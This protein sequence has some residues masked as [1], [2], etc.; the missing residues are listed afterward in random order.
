MVFAKLLHD[1]WKLVN[2]GRLSML[3][4][5]MESQI[6]LEEFFDYCWPV[7]YQMS[8]ETEMSR[9]EE[10]VNISEKRKGGTSIERGWAEVRVETGNG[11]VDGKEGT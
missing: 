5:V 10:R 8:S 9:N 1:I 6:R 3:V 7:N 4:F 11:K 2:S